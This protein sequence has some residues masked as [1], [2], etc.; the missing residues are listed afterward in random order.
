VVGGLVSGNG[1]G[2]G[3]KA[4]HFPFVIGGFN[5]EVQQRIAKNTEAGALATAFN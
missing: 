4:K 5:F 1:L 2:A 3:G